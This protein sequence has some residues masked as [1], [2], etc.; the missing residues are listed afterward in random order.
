MSDN[1]V[2]AELPDSFPEITRF[3]IYRS[4]PDFSFIA[5]NVS[6]DECSC[7]LTAFEY[8]GANANGSDFS[9]TSIREID[10][11][12]AG[13]PWRKESNEWLFGVVYTDA[14]SSSSDPDIP[15]LGVTSASLVALENLFQSSTFVTSWVEGNYPNTNLGFAAAL[16]GVDV[17]VSERFANMAASMTHAVRYGPNTQLTRGEVVQSVP[18]VS[19]RWGCFVVPIVTEG[20]A[21]LFAV[22]SILSNRKSRNVPL[23]KSSTLAVLAIQLNEQAGLLKGTSNGILE[24]NAAAEKAEVRLQ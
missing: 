3:G 11:G 13:N 10:F 19:I 1:L 8:S 2:S 4:T 23:W 17:D 21:I 7:Y 20:L 6:I 24:I 9:F 16:S 22:F 15:A 18:Y 5:H 12:G 14:L